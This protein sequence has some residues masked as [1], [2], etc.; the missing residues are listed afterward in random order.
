M[1]REGL[2]GIAYS[3]TGHPGSRQTP[4]A[5]ENVIQWVPCCNKLNG[6]LGKMNLKDA[7]SQCT[8]NGTEY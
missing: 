6:D 8:G 5:P 4:V 1:G 2:Y 7:E 3:P